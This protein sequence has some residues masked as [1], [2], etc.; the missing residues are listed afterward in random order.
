MT[1]NPDHLLD[2]AE[3]LLS[4]SRPG[5]PRQADLRRSVSSAYY[6]LFHFVLRALADE[7][8]GASRRRS[9]R[10]ALLYRSVEHRALRELCLEAT[11]QR[12]S[13]RYAPYVP[14]HGFGAH[15]L[16]FSATAVELQGRRLAADYS[17]LASFSAK[18]AKLAVGAA[19]DAIQRFGT[20]DEEQRR[21]YLTLLL[22]P[23]RQG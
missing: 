20:A 9:A 17:P 6:A 8:V 23:P 10:Y 11:K 5:P 16:A 14:E 18:D 2:Q 13:S 15:L 21:M 22:C 12:P 7:F 3:R 19:R 4:S 1:T